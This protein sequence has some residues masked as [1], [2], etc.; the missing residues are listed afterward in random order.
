VRSSA[1]GEASAFAALEADLKRYVVLGYDF[2]LARECGELLAARER[3]GQRMEEFDAWIAAT[4]LRHDI[5][6]AT[7]N[8]KHFEGIPDLRLV[9]P[10]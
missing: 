3:I 7:N 8:R 2:A 5:P 4:A 1:G 10:G 9:S 6:L